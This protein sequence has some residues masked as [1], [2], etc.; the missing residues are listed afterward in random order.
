MATT[1]SLPT[2]NE[3]TFSVTSNFGKRML[4]DVIQ[5]NEA[6]AALLHQAKK[7]KVMHEDDEC[8]ATPAADDDW[9]SPRD[10]SDVDVFH[11]VVP[12]PTHRDDEPEVCSDEDKWLLEYFLS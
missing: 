2:N 10:V 3:A 9:D 5:C 7:R 8:P 1:L 6:D 4:I 12:L 11:P